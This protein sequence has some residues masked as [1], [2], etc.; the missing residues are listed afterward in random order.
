MRVKSVSK[1]PMM[2]ARFRRCERLRESW[3][4]KSVERG[5]ARLTTAKLAGSLR[6]RS[7]PCKTRVKGLCKSHNAPDDGEVGGL[8]EG[9]VRRDARQVPRRRRVVE[10]ALP[11]VNQV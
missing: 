11:L 6:A 10:Q 8:A 1:R 3:C 4:V 2:L 5:P 7:P 9:Q